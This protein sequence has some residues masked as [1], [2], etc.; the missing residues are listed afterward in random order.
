MAERVNH[1]PNESLIVKEDLLPP[2]EWLL[3]PVTG[4]IYGLDDE[5]RVAEVL[6][7]NG[8]ILRSV[9]KLCFSTSS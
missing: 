8:K 5:K 6:T 2:T 7:K 9:V 1:K 3:G 4:F